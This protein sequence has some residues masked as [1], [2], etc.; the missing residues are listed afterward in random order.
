M[1]LFKGDK[2]KAWEE[3]HR[4]ILGTPSRDAELELKAEIES[5]LLTQNDVKA[6]YYNDGTTEGYT[7]GDSSGGVYWPITTATP[8]GLQLSGPGIPVEPVFIPEK[9]DPFNGRLMTCEVCGATMKSGGS[10]W[11]AVHG[12]DGN[13]YYFCPEHT[14]V[15]KMEQLRNT[16]R[17]YRDDR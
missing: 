16:G 9:I 17:V 15:E 13:I 1:A 8:L 12:T 7:W 4:S 14:N 11:W 2:K 10:G 3:A 6:E 5:V